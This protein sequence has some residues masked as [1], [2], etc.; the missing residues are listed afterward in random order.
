MVEPYNVIFAILVWVIG[1][2]KPLAQNLLDL[3]N[4]PILYGFH[5]CGIR[6][7]DS[8]SN[9]APQNRNLVRTEDSFWRN[10][11]QLMCAHALKQST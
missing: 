1:K 8:L 10:S 4:W 3:R 5:V 9:E 6:F 11:V 7:Q 2:V